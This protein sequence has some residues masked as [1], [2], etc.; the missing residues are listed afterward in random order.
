RK[1]P[2]LLK[3]TKISLEQS[4]KVFASQWLD[5][6]KVVCGT[7]SNQLY[8]IDMKTK[9]RVN[10]PTLE[11]SEESVMPDVSTGIH[12]IQ[13]NEKKLLAT[14]G[15]NPNHL[16]VYR[17]PTF[18]PVCVGEAHTDW[19]FATEWIDN[20][21]VTTGS[22]D[23]SIALWEIPVMCSATPASSL[24][25]IRPPVIAPLSTLKSNLSTNR[26]RDLAFNNK[27]GHL[28]ALSPLAFIHIWDMISEKQV[29]PL[30]FHH[31]NVCL[32]FQEECSL[33]AV[34]SQSH[35]SLLD[36]KTSKPIHNV[37]TNDIG[38]GV[39]SVSF[40][41]MM[42]TIGTG[43]GSVYFY[44]IRAN[45]FLSKP[46]Q[47]L[48]YLRSGKGWLRPDSTLFDY[49]TDQDTE[50]FRNAIY[51]HCYDPTGTKLFTAGGPLALVLYG[52]Y[53]ALWE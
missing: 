19:V 26:I 48:F 23:G 18:D 50:C 14:S 22:R 35:V 4:D 42:V 1:I 32:A 33:Y 13:I 17:I 21:H 34:G 28:A 3:P 29:I 47:E 8:V 46:T 40:K 37:M 51:T 31:E 25:G 52:N 7:K 38:A 12:D 44:D 11:G 30:P 27:T 15:E 5:E 9:K 6:Q 2:Y 36:A 20:N 24:P 53:A 49:F 45:R 10:I 39:R 16:A 41:D 43:H